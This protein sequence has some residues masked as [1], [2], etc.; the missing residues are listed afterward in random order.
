MENNTDILRKIQSGDPQLLD[1]AIREI[2]ENGDLSMAE[3]LLQ[4]L[5]QPLDFHLT[6]TIVNLLAD[7]KDNQ[8]S[9]IVIQKL[10][11]TASPHQKSLLIRIAWESALNYSRHM[12]VFTGLL[13]DEDFSVALEASTALENMIPQLN[14]TQKASLS[15]LLTEMTLPHDKNFLTGNILALLAGTEEEAG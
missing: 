15:R 6:N 7:I 12:A 13:K 4:T 14:E 1:A 10:Q 9:E 11:T 5:E 2:Q 8:F 3:A